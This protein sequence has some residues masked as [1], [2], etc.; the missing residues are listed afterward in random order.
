MQIIEKDWNVLLNMAV[1]CNVDLASLESARVLRRT[2]LPLMSAYG[3][4]HHLNEKLPGLNRAF[5]V[6]DLMGRNE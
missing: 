6:Y 1:N 2:L 5:K 3:I 4:V